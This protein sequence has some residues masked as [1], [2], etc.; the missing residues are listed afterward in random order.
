MPTRDPP[1]LPDVLKPEP[2]TV[3]L[4][5]VWL[6]RQGRVDMSQRQIAAALGLTQPNVS[7]AV[8]RL[9]ELGLVDTPPAARPRVKVPLSVRTGS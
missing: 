7:G 4:L 2:P 1:S 3:K 9:R 6:A 8:T 5:Y